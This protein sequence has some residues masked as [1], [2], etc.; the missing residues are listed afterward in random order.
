M[1][2]AQTA[3]HIVAKNDKRAKITRAVLD[4]F[5]IGVDAAANGVGLPQKFHEA[6]HT[7][8]YYQ[9]IEEAAKTW[10]TENK[11][12]KACK[13]LLTNC[14]SWPK[15]FPFYETLQTFE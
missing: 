2:N 7:T 8:R 10:L 6:L 11:Q 15:E 14:L 5:K 9:T 12:S 3:H 13:R 4:K 1:K